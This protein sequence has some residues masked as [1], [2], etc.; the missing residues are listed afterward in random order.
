MLDD[1]PPPPS[2]PR[3]APP[4]PPDDG[5]AG[6]APGPGGPLG[7]PVA[8]VVPL[9]APDGARA[10]GRLYLAEGPV[11]AGVVLT[12]AM[13]VAARYY[14]AFAS[15]LASLGL[16][17]LVA[18]LRGIATSS[19]RAGRAVDF[20]YYELAALDLP[21]ALAALRERCRGVPIFLAGHSLGGQISLLFAALFPGEVAG[22]ALMASGSPH[23]LGWPAGVRLGVLGVFGLLTRIS[24]GLGYLPG[25]ALGFG[26]REARRLIAEWAAW[27][28]T[29]RLEPR[30]A[31]PALDRAFAQIDLP[32]LSLSFGGDRWAPFGPIE[33]LLAMVPRAPKTRVHFRR[34]ALGA[35][36]DH[37]RWAKHPARPARALADWALDA[38]V[39]GGAGRAPRS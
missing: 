34:G 26:G 4:A 22:V 7:A 27:G 18:E 12:P 16:T 9:C 20:G 19:V 1:A 33:E 37:F 13:G 8:I 32:V 24:R 38:A 15:E 39:R 6:R 25:R 28:R 35:P 21:A 14:D 36:V 10:E 11:L 5:A 29:G 2:V 31:P 30:G 23:Y 17:V 3:D